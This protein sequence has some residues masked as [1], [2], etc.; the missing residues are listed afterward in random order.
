VD[1][2]FKR[3]KRD[4]REN[5]ILDKDHVD[6]EKDSV[7]DL[8]SLLGDDMYCRIINKLDTACMEHSMLELWKFSQQ[9]IHNLTMEKIIKALNRT[10]VR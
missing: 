3:R 8:G 1:F 6:H 5:L 7:F 4:E 9:T 10:T 2:I